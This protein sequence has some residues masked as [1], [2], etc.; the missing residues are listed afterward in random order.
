MIR[1]ENVIEYINLL[2][3]LLQSYILK[4]KT[5]LT[6]PR[7]NFISKWM[8]ERKYYKIAKELD[9]ELKSKSNS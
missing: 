2:V 3:R 6:L 5:Y 7:V 9:Q 4:I 8:I 1:D